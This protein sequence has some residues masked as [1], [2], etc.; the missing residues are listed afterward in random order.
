[1]E[2]IVK[3]GILYDYYGDLLTEHQKK[4]YEDFAYNNLSL[5][6][7]GKEYQISRQAVYDIIRRS[8]DAMMLFEDRLKMI[9]RF[10]RIRAKV[11]E[12]S[13]HVNNK[14]IGR[15]DLTVIVN[16]IAEEILDELM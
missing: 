1:M 15:T 12:L 2:K 11:D 16:T 5:S 7:I 13:G 4:I 3:Q 10:K 14:F 6:E 9:D 8:D